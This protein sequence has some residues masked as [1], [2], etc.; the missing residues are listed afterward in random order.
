MDVTGL[1]A[2]GA[3]YLDFPMLD[4][5]LKLWNRTI[6]SLRPDWAAQ[7]D[8]DSKKNNNQEKNLNIPHVRIN[9]MDML[10]QDHKD[11]SIFSPI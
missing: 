4:H 9:S 3:H 5:N 11:V 1:A 6:P 8:L 2:S 7:Q 10:T